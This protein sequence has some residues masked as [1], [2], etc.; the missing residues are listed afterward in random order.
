M[1]PYTDCCNLTLINYSIYI[2]CHCKQR[3]LGRSETKEGKV[4]PPCP[5]V[6]ADTEKPF[7][8]SPPHLAVTV[9]TVRY[10]SVT[11]SKG[12]RITNQKSPLQ[13]CTSTGTVP[14]CYR[15]PRPNYRHRPTKSSLMPLRWGVNR[16]N[17]PYSSQYQ[18]GSK[19]D[20]LRQLT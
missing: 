19:R 1:I 12:K 2:T 16:N 6:V 9:C 4:D 14:S 7:W 13:I 8:A 10:S 18:R 11:D 5:S 17:M 3:S 15:T 20:P